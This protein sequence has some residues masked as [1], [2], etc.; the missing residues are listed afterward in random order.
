MGQINRRFNGQS[1]KIYPDVLTAS[2][3]YTISTTTDHF[4]CALLL[5]TVLQCVVER[6]FL[7]S[8]GLVLESSDLLLLQSCLQRRVEGFSQ[9]P[10][11]IYA[12]CLPEL[13]LCLGL[14]C[15]RSSSLMSNHIARSFIKLP[16]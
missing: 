11:H 7:H 5:E 13:G 8:H 10:R 3:P 9:F 14:S 4:C 1:H 6:L 2:S 16:Y 15:R 12:V